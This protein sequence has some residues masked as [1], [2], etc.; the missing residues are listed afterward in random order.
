MRNIWYI[1]LC[2][3][4]D[5]I[6]GEPY[7]SSTLLPWHN[8]HFWY[9]RTYV[10]HLLGDNPVVVPAKAHLLAIAGDYQY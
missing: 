4:I 5:L 10:D 1:Y 9:A 3:Q 8:L 7:F 6:V 2:Y